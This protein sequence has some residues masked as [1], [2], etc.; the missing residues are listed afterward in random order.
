[1]KTE[2]T[3]G[4]DQA[5]EKALIWCENHKGWKRICDIK[6]SDSLY[7]KWVD[8]TK[9]EK[10]PWVRD[11]GISADSVWNDNKGDT[12]KVPYGFISGEGEF[13]KDILQVPLFHNL[14]MIFKVN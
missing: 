9:E 1:M 3:F 6:D 7:K 2:E 13:Y 8:L 5:A 14:M 12:C 4:T 10:Y 11:F